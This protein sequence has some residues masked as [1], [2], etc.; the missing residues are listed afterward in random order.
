MID[1]AKALAM[2]AL[3]LMWK[4]AMLATARRRISMRRP[5]FPTAALA[6]LKRK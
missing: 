1:G 6:R 3:D 2:T 4:P 5:M